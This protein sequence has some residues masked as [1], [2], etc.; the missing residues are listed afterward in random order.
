MKFTHKLDKNNFFGIEIK[1]AYKK[2]LIT[3]LYSKRQKF[4]KN[5]KCTVNKLNFILMT[6]N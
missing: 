4:T 6:L 5:K 3:K 1:L 2:D